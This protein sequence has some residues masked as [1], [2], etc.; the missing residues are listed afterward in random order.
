M[1]RYGVI[2][3]SIVAFLG[4]VIYLVHFGQAAIP[5]YHDFKGE[6]AGYTTFG[7]IFKGA[8]AFN[9][10]EVI[11]LGV[12]VLIATPILR[13]ALSLVAFAV[14]KDKLYVF[15]TLIVLCVIMT[16]IFGGLKV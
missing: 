15:I 16:S 1:L 4:G 7:G 6:G 14:E 3:A 9:A 5:N 13:I 2:T 8:F 11:Q 10:T 12:L